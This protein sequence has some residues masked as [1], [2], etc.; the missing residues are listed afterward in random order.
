MTRLAVLM[1]YRNA[2]RYIKLAVESI[3][4]QTYSNFTVFAINDHGADESTDII[5]SICDSRIC[6]VES[7]GTGISAASTPACGGVLD[8][9]WQPAT[10]P[11]TYP[12]P[13]VSPS[14]KARS[15]R[16]RKPPY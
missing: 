8:I 2:G 3:L 5:R 11:M 9:P 14:K 7:A 1:P 12:I 15:G 16:I 6:I 13:I 10:T 4:A